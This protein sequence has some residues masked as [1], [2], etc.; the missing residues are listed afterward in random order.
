MFGIQ[1]KRCGFPKNVKHNIKQVQL[2]DFKMAK[3]KKIKFSEKTLISSPKS[4]T[5]LTGFEIVYDKKG[6]NRLGKNC[7]YFFPIDSRGN[8]HPM[9][10]HGIKKDDAIQLIDFLNEIIKDEK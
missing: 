9:R 10:W 8:T 7:L 5:E 4:L 2:E 6:K 3:P 1:T